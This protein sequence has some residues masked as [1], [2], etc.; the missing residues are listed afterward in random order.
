MLYFYKFGINLPKPEFSMKKITLMFFMCFLSLGAFAQFPEGFEGTW[1]NFTTGAG[2]AGPGGPAGWY[3]RNITGAL[4]WSL[5]PATY[6]PHTGVGAAFINRQVMP[7]GQLAEDWLV[8]PQATAIPANGEL[9]FW[10]KLNGSGD[11]GSH[12]YVYMND[13]AGSTQ[14]TWADYDVI[15]DWTEATINSTQNAWQEKTV[16]L[17]TTATTAYFAFVMTNNAGDIWVVDDIKIVA[18]CLAPT[19]LTAGNFTLNSADLSWANPSGATQFEIAITPVSGNLGGSGTVFTSATPTFHATQTEP[20]GV[21]FTPDTDYR[22][23]VRAICADGGVST[24]WGGPYA[25]STLAPGETCATPLYINDPTAP[26]NTLPFSSPVGATTA[27]FGDTVDGSP[28]ATGCGTTGNF[29]NGNDVFYSYTATFTGSISVDL[30]G[31]TGASGVFMYT[32]CA[33]IG[34]SCVAGGTGNATTPVSLPSVAVT[35]GQTYYFVVS[36][37]VQVTP[38]T[39]VIQEVHCAKPV[40]QPTTAIG[41]NTATLNW[42]NPSG[43]S[44]WQVVVQAQGTGLPSNSTTTQPAT[45]NTGFTVTSVT[46]GGA[47]QEATNY[48]YYV[49][50]DCGDGTFSQWAG[51]FL[52]MT[53]QVPAGL[54]Y[55][56]DFE[57]ATNGFSLSNGTQTNKWVVGTAASNNSTKGLYISN[58]N[59]LTNAYTHIASTVH[60][61]RDI[62][63]TTTIDQIAFSFDWRSL[64]ENNFDFLR[65]WLVPATFV[66]TPGTLITATGGNIPVGAGTFQLSNTWQT[67]NVPV[68]ASSFSNSTMRVVF[69]WRNDGGGGTPPP[70]AV[71]NI[72]ISILTCPQPTALTLGTFTETS[73]NFS[74]TAPT[75]VTPTYDYYWSQSSTPPTASTPETGNTGTATTLS[76]SGLTPSTTYFLWVRSDCGSGNTS[77]WTGPLQFT[78]PQIPA[79]MNY[80][81][82]FDGAPGTTGWTLSNGTQPNV[83]AIGSA[84]SLSPSNSLYITNDGGTTNNYDDTQQ[85]TVHAYRDITIPAV[86]Q[87][88]IQF[89]W[90][91]LGESCCDFVNVW[92]VPTTF[93][94]TPGTQIANGGGRIR[95]TPT[96]LNLSTGWQHHNFTFNGSSFSSTIG[97]LVFEWRDDTSVGDPPVAIDNI[98]LSII[99]CPQPSNLAVDAASIT[100][101]SANISWTGPTSVTPTYD[102]YLSTDP[103]APT[104]TTVPTGNVTPTNASLGT[105]PLTPATTYF[106]WV[107]SHCSDTDQ[108]F[109]TGPISFNTLQVPVDMDYEESFEGT[110]GWTLNNGT[111]T[112]K[113]VVGT[114]TSLSPTHSLYISNDNGT[115]NA[116]TH[117]TSTVHAY[118]DITFPDAIDQASLEFDWK[119]IGENGFDFFRVW[120]VPLTFTP[121]PGT[122]I[123]AG[124]GRVPI[125]A[126]NTNFQSSADWQHF[127]FILNAG[128][129]ATTTQ[130][131]VFEWRNDGGGGVQPPAAIDNFKLKTIL[132]PQPSNLAMTALVTTPTPSVT[133]SWTAPTS[134]TP[135][136]DYFLLTSATPPTE[137]T[138]P[139]GNTEDNTVTI[140]D[141]PAGATNFYFYLR[142]N[143][144]EDGTSFLLGPINFGLPLTPSPLDYNEDFDGPYSWT[145]GNGTQANKWVVGPA[146]FN[147]PANSLYISNNNGA[148][149]AYTITTGSVVH[150]Y[151]DVQLP[152][153]IVQGAI[154][155]DWKG[156]GETNDFMKVW[157]VPTTFVPT[158]GTAIT[159]AAD[160]LPIGTTF[161][162]QPAW[163]HEIFVQDM[164]AMAGTPRRLIFEWTNNTFTGTQPPAAVDN[165]EVKKVTCPQPTNL[166]TEGMDNNSVLLTW[167]PAGTETQWEVVIQLDG[168]AY[169][170]D[171]PTGSVII[172]DDEDE[173]E[174]EYLWEGATP[175][176][177]YEYYVRAICSDDDHSFWSGPFFFSIFTPPGCADVD[178]LDP[179]LNVIASGTEFV[180]CPGESACVELNA[181]YYHTGNTD[182]YEVESIAYNPPFPFIGGT[183][184]NISTD[185]IWGPPVTLPF[186]F[187]FFG[188]S[189]NQAKVGSNGVVQFGPA[190]ANDWASTFCPWSYTQSVP[191]VPIRN[192]IYGVYQDILPNDSGD[193]SI[194]FQVLGNYPCRALVVNYYEVPQFSCGLGVGTQTS[195]IVIYEITNIVEV[196]VQKRTSCTGWNGGNGV[197]G[198]ENGTNGTPA[199]FT[200][201]GRN[202]GTWNAT[203]EAW[204]FTPNGDSNVVFEWL[205][206]GEHYSDEDDI[207][208][209]IEDTATMTAKAVY[210]QCTGEEIVRAS[211]IELRIVNP[212]IIADPADLAAC[213]N[214]ED[215]T[216]DLNE[217][218]AGLSTDYEYTFYPTEEAA[219]EGGDDNLPVEYVT[220]T[221][222]TIWVRIEYDGCHL[223]NSFELTLSNIP[224]VFTVTAGLGTDANETVCAGTPVT[225]TVVPGNFALADATYTWTHD[226]EPMTDTTSTITVTEGGNYEVTVNRD[227]CVGTAQS[228]I[229]VTPIPVP[230]D[231]EDVTACGEYILPV[232]TVGEY[233]TGPLGTG[234]HLSANDPVSDSQTIY[235]YAVTA[236]TPPCSAQ[237]SFV[238]TVVPRPEIAPVADVYA[239]DSYTLPNAPTGTGY[240]T[241]TDGSGTPIANGTV[242]DETQLIYVYA[243][244][245]G[246]ADCGAQTSFTVHIT[247]S[248]VADDLADVTECDTYTLPA[249]SAGNNYYTATNKGGVMLSA[250]E[251]VTDSQT[252]FVY[253]EVPTGNPDG[254]V[255][256][257]ETSFVVTIVPKPVLAPVADL[258]A[259][260]SYTLPELTVGGYFADENGVDP[261][262]AGTVIT[263]DQL[264]YVYADA[265][266]TGCTAEASFTV[267]I[268][269]QPVADAP[270]NVSECDSYT[271]LPLSSGAYYTSTDGQG[272]QL[273]AG[274]NITVSQTIYVYASNGV[275]ADENSFEVEIIDRPQVDATQY[276]DNNDYTLEVVFKDDLYTEDNVNFVWLSPSGAEIATTASVVI[277]EKGDYHLIV[278]PKND[279]TSCPVDIVVPVTETTCSIPRGI[280]PDNDGKNDEFDLST[281]DVRKI[282]I[283]N[284]YGKEVFSY[285]NYTNQWHGQQDNGN[286]L[287]TGTYFYVI[288]RGNGES[289]TG[290]VYINRRD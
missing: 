9:H 22:Y 99:T 179:D 102:Y 77:F 214:G 73:A 29:L 13:T 123:T 55:V 247:V 115:T 6:P 92:L 3:I 48:E 285:T 125:P 229:T 160:R 275:C 274:T 250:G 59:G 184:L 255:C 188:T 279:T 276:C 157:L 17:N 121:T 215:V 142:S 76:M 63:I 66:P 265:G 138:V 89:D 289:K 103:T 122:Q 98:N 129:Y 135:S 11:T 194:N 199:G 288:E 126:A 237:N 243:A 245:T 203:N 30:S 91:V 8:S 82:N 261:I 223:V 16:L 204:R 47:L 177:F 171:N 168:G 72:N 1:T 190:N 61:Y 68:T 90:N 280:S 240:F 50:A 224:P 209:C 230:D 80:T 254:S 207:T 226:D 95:L 112:N 34:V 158:P 233:Y 173:T 84:I 62:A 178:V 25:F 132:C 118:R 147:S 260:E 134:V 172:G 75:S 139:T 217:S 58:D 187:C 252:I 24:T 241:G 136:Y 183:E 218:V 231:P 33:N 101:T 54:P 284:R 124:G 200:P 88:N 52:F 208:V 20:A 74:W 110:H 264:I 175:N 228:L 213:S 287:P 41:S 249:L 137:D 97:R 5:T 169:P 155:F 225:I 35:Q 259:C 87:M 27:N 57:G 65:V 78:T 272:E 278:T 253:T 79:G 10:S 210:T 71:D 176:V 202:T 28:G 282:S 163:T 221:S 198:I 45:V 195:Q 116:Y 161:K 197:I 7:A 133:F 113:W 104:G 216:F 36:G 258:D 281:L 69:E 227:G 109:W 131:I 263:E 167:D 206:D 37:T 96:N 234:V 151:T 165:V 201:P 238:V 205:K 192:A 117:T 18:P 130:R 189:Y 235:V 239:C 182:T 153:D 146:T 67:V 191:N 251:A 105:P 181:E 51:P 286:E 212:I 143:C 94:P 162:G 42:T 236:T 174:P 220:N 111:Q 107:R 64:G 159:P 270:A 248:P 140:T 38:Y 283:Y 19:T 145:V 81:Q 262:A 120:L 46:G 196:Y 26:V 256:S 85:S 53:T 268:L 186:D 290:W 15:A 156:I 60:A 211:D 257:N 49:R 100:Q 108:S 43:A 21:A 166:A 40:G 154:S 127:L 4:A 119:S 32:S 269:P 44:A 14:T 31:M 266:V 149:N 93:T 180:I 242:I 106:V 39:L 2:T 114:A 170:S 246:A 232:L 185:D 219:E 56:Q 164:S 273:S 267:T 23:W 277:N 244:A 12:Y 141:F 83:W 193:V 222:E 128:A 271:L 152:G 86:D 144:G 148:N 70:A 150:A